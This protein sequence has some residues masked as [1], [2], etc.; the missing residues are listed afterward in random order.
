V[1]IIEDIDKNEVIINDIRIEGSIADEKCPKCNNFLILYEK[2]DSYFCAYCNEWTER[3]CS[4][5]DCFFFVR[6]DPKNLYE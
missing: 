5:P 1:K 3:K 6:I 4:D 2:Y